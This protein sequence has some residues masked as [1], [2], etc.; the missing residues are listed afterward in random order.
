MTNC[1][2]A[3]NWNNG[4]PGA[5]ADAIVNSGS[6]LLTNV[7]A[8]LGSLTFNNGTLTFSNWTTKVT[9]TNVTMTNGT[10][11]LPAAFTEAQM[12]NRVWV[13]ASNF[14]LGADAKIDTDDKGYSGEQGPGKSWGSGIWS[15]RSGGGSQSQGPRNHTG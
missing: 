5:G 10:W 4:V 12:S 1:F 11:T 9:A 2:D 15:G 3:N 14:F 8:N 7:T 13:V 6:I